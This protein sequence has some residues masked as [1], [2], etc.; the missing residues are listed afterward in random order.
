MPDQVPKPLE[1]PNLRRRLVTLDAIALVLA[2][3][4][5]QIWKYSV[6]AELWKNLVIEVV[7]LA[8]GLAL[9]RAQG[10]YLARVA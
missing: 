3:L 8:S 1:A 2:W 9:L 6:G 5:A 10:L 7:L 4:P